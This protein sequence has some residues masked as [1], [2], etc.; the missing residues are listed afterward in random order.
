MAKDP[1]YKV[2]FAPQ[3]AKYLKEKPLI[4]VSTAVDAASLGLNTGFSVVGSPDFLL[5]SSPGPNVEN[6]RPQFN[7]M[8]DQAYTA[9]NRIGQS[10]RKLFFNR[11]IIEKLGVIGDPIPDFSDEMNKDLLE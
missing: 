10:V 9:I 7:E 5:S 4:S 8:Y 3:L 6:T 1:K 11:G 2:R